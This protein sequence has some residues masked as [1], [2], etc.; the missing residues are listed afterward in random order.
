MDKGEVIEELLYVESEKRK[1]LGL[2]KAHG[3]KVY[4]AI[5]RD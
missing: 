4:F 2:I 5:P 1:S 3:H